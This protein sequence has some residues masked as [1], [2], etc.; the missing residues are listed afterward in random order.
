MLFTTPIAE[1]EISSGLLVRA[2]RLLIKEDT[3]SVEVSSVVV[4]FCKPCSSCS[5]AV[6]FACISSAVKLQVKPLYEAW[7][8]QYEVHDNSPSLHES[9]P[10]PVDASL[11]LHWPWP[12]QSCAHVFLGSTHTDFSHT[13]QF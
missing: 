10:A 13:F 2:P 9:T 11:Y 6:C 8:S 3:L 5:R 4:M 12:E 1:M 7:H